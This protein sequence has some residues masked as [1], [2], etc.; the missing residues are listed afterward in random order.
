MLVSVHGRTHRSNGAT[1]IYPSLYGRGEAVKIVKKAFF[2]DCYCPEHTLQLVV[3][4]DS[5]EDFVS[6][7]WMLGDA[8]TFTSKLKLVFNLLFRPSRVVFQETILKPED[9]I[10]LGAT[11]VRDVRLPKRLRNVG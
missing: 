5:D 7:T 2:C 8:F 3:M 11:L 9:A 4:Q 6:V 10:N 1:H